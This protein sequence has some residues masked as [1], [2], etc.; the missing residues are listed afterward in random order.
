HQV[1]AA[2]AEGL[3]GPQR[4][5]AVI[6]HVGAEAVDDEAGAAEAVTARAVTERI[7]GQLRVQDAERRCVRRRV[8]AALLVEAGGEPRLGGRETRPGKEP[9]SQQRPEGRQPG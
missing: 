8:A 3:P 7:E 6:L 1:A 5:A 2:A 9:A 4:P